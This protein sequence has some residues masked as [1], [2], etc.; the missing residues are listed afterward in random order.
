MLDALTPPAPDTVLGMD[1]MVLFARRWALNAC[2]GAIGSSLIPVWLRSGLLGLLDIEAR[3]VRI[4]HHVTIDG[5]N[6]SI[7]HRTFIGTQSF[8]EGPVAPLRI[9]SACAIATG[10]RLM[11]VTHDEGSH[12]GRAGRRVHR[13]TSIGDGCWIGAGATIMPGVTVAAGCII[14]AGAVVTKDTAPDGVYV[15]V[16]ARRIRE[17]SPDA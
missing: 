6:I 8:L 9:G 11:T 12:D 3:D 17:L 2:L 10:V 16:P 1:D 13:A 14:G 4:A 15:G 7:G 5:R